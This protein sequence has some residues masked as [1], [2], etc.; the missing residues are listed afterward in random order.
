MCYI[1]RLKP[2]YRMID[3]F[4]RR[5]W[6]QFGVHKVAMMDNGVFMVRFRTK[7]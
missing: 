7:E 4:I 5:V 1:L 6:M 2:P 3:G